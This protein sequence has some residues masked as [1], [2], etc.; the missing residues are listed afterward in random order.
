[1][2]KSTLARA[3]LDAH[4]KRDDLVTF[5]SRCYERELVP[6]NAVDGL[7]DSVAHFLRRAPDAYVEHI[8]PARAGVIAQVFP[9]LARVGVLA[10]STLPDL[11]LDRR[12]VRAWLF[13]AIRELFANIARERPVIALVDDLH[14]ADNDSMT[15]LAELLRE[16]GSPRMLLLCTRRTQGGAGP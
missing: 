9:V 11:T 12:E 16:P 7:L 6:Y 14:W 4:A 13:S 10:R 1:V 15:L 2:G 3:F 8:L 5:F